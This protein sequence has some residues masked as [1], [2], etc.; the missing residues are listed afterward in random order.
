MAQGEL[1]RLVM[2]AT[3][4]TVQDVPASQPIRRLLHS[5]GFRRVA[6]TG[7]WELPRTI[8]RAVRAARIAEVVRVLDMAHIPLLFDDRRQPPANSRENRARINEIYS[9]NWSFATGHRPYVMAVAATVH[10]RGMPV[11]DYDAVAG[12]LAADPAAPTG[13]RVTARTGSIELA[14]GRQVSWDEAAGWRDMATG[15]PL[16]ISQIADPATVATAI[17]ALPAPS[18]V[19][20]GRDPSE[21]D[22]TFEQALAAYRRHPGVE[23]LLVAEAGDTGSHAL[24]LMPQDV[25]AVRQWQPP[26]PAPGRWETAS[27]IES[28]GGAGVSAAWPSTVGRAAASAYKPPAPG[29]AKQLRQARAGRAQAAAQLREAG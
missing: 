23:A 12:E 20:S 16:P 3:S 24:Q 7:H 13:V 29:A 15:Q 18:T 28:T 27:L 5:N 2:D 4:T 6:E 9:G 17:A 10:V 14:D 25:R 11:R 1:M 21:L 22:P 19:V 26:E 8:P